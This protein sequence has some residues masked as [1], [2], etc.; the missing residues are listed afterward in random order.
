MQ[1]QR[2]LKEIFY[3]Y[4]MKWKKVLGKIGYVR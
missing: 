1:L 2:K 3:I 4:E